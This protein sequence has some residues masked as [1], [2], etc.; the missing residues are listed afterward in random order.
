MGYEDAQF[1]DDED[2]PATPSASQLHSLEEEHAAFSLSGTVA[3]DAWQGVCTLCGEPLQV[4]WDDA[5]R[6]L[7]VADAVMFRH[8]IYHA[9]C[10]LC[11][12]PPLPPVSGVLR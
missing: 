8:V 3:A 9:G 1:S 2:G 10:A 6:E 12:M 11:A 5:R 7:V 4:T